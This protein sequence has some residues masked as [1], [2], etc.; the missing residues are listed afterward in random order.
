MEIYRSWNVVFIDQAKDGWQTN[1]HGKK[2]GTVWNFLTK[3]HKNNNFNYVN[4]Q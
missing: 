1:S 4:L 2:T 3:L